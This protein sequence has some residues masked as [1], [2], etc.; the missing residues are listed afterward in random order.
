MAERSR[1]AG[2]GPTLKVGREFDGEGLLEFLAAHLVNLSKARL[3]Q[4]L[5]SGGVALNARVAT[6][7]DRVRAGDVV[8]LPPD[9]Q[10]GPPPEQQLSLRVLFEDARH[11]CVDKP[12]GHPV[13]PGRH[14]EGG[15]FFT[16]LLAYLNRDAA[17][18]GPYRRPHL[19]HRLDR[20][21]SGVLLV[22]KDVEAGRCLSRQFERG[23]VRKTYLGVIEGVLPRDELEVD[24]PV[25]RMSG[26]VI[27][28]EAAGR[29]G[30][31]ARTSLALKE[32]FGHFS[33]LSIQPRTGR[34]HQIRVHLAAIGYPLAVDAL[35]GRRKV[36]RGEDFNAI[37]GHEAA[38]RSAVLLA[39]CPLHAASVRYRHPETGR[40]METASS[41]PLD[42]KGFLELLREQDPAS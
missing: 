11:L 14:G 23:E 12:P 17:P 38:R 42:M 35:Y 27:K 6:G 19:V 29:R 40:P 2:D 20:D 5:A 41:L 3:R 32:R 4:M 37:V 25:R 22:A 9:V 26:S 36:L 24:I 10:L 21:T 31:T 30:K 15:E 34:Q 16:S 39:R 7:M 8:Q 33:L 18:G 28:M 13:L 1:L